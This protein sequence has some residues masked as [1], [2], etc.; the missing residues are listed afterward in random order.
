MSSEFADRAIQA[1]DRA[2]REAPQPGTTMPT[3]A[4]V[5]AL[6]ELRFAVRELS[7]LASLDAGVDELSVSWV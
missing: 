7:L 2:L 6:L 3:E 5:D 1:I 4:H